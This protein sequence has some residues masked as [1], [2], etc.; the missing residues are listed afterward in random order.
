MQEG[1]GKTTEGQQHEHPQTGAERT[2]E[3]HP[4]AVAGKGAGEWQYRL[5]HCQA[6]RQH[7][8]EITEFRNHGVP[9]AALRS[10]AASS[11]AFTSADM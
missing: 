4:Q 2:P 10:A 5:Q 1:V 11:A 7:C 8:R 6:Q 3:T 9:P